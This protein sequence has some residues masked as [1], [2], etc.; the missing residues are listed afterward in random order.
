[1]LFC[2]LSPLF[3]SIYGGKKERPENE[4]DSGLIFDF[5][6]GMRVLLFLML[7]ITGLEALVAQVDDPSKRVDFEI[8]EDNFS[9]PDGM[10][11]PALKKPSLSN[12]QDRNNPNTSLLDLKEEEKVDFTKD[13]GLKEFESNR[14]PKAFIKDKEIKE[15]YGRD[16]NLGDVRTTGGF[17]QIKY[18]DHEYV[19]GDRIRV[20]VNK[21]IVRSDV[22]L[23]GSFSGFTANLEDGY[24]E[25]IF[26]ALNQGSSGPNTAELH[27]YNDKG[28]II[29]ASEWNLLTGN[30]AT[31]V[32]IK[33]KEF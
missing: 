29:S 28:Q 1:M 6:H 9:D 24:N 21:D 31:I 5:E 8:T 27:V 17:V 13:D 4:R 19:D 33:E 12:F 11:M 7:F 18:R 10:Q 15:E 30:K 16:Q 20:F 14:I 23:G 26:Q 2:R 22:T 25:I 3:L 32:V